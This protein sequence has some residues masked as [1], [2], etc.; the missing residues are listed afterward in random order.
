VYYIL[1]ADKIVVTPAALEEIKN[2]LTKEEA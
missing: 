2:W 1:N